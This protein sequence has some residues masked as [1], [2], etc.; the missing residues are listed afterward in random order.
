MD[1]RGHAADGPTEKRPSSG[2]SRFRR[3]SVAFGL[4][5][6]PVAGSV[7]MA[8]AVTHADAAPAIEPVAAHVAAGAGAA[9]DRVGA[10]TQAFADAGYTYEDAVALSRSWGVP[11]VSQTKVKA[12][13]FLVDG[14]PLAATPYANPSAADGLSDTQLAQLFV[15]TGYTAD[16]AVKLAGKWSVDAG[17]AKVKAGRELKTVGVLPFVDHVGLNPDGSPS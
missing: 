17:L 4:I 5:G 10:A 7:L 13:S 11:D 9:Q 16:D 12:G 3:P 14:V 1:P 2:Q 15:D 6:L 8:P